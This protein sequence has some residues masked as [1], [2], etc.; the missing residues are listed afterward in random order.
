MKKVFFLLLLF[1]IVMRQ[2]IYSQSSYHYNQIQLSSSLCYN[3]SLQYN[4]HDTLNISTTCNN[5]RDSII[6]VSNYKWK[7]MELFLNSLIVSWS[8]TDEIYGKW[9]RALK[10]IFIPY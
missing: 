6:I 2:K 3:D 8:S 9:D 10:N 1:L 5:K 4:N 7:N